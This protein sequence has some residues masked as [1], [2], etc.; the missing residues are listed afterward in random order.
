VSSNIPLRSTAATGAP[1]FTNPRRFERW[2]IVRPGY[3]TAI[4]F[5]VVSFQGRQIQM[6]S[7]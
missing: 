1:S 7:P 3:R 6:M 2:L 5:H 4:Q